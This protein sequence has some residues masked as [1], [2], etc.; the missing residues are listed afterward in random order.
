MTDATKREIHGLTNTGERVYLGA[1]RM[2]D[3]DVEAFLRMIADAFAGS[4]PGYFNVRSSVY[5]VASFAG[6]QVTPPVEVKDPT[7]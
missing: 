3:D 4:L 1:A 2:S 7:P 5:N 6:V